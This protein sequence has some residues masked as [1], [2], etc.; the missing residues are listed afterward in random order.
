MVLAAAA[1]LGAYAAALAET[2]P[3]DSVTRIL[4]APEAP[5]G[6]AVLGFRGAVLDCLGDSP[7]VENRTAR[8][9]LRLESVSVRGRETS[10][11]G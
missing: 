10:V 7:Y 2:V 11:S 5:R 3:P 6:G 4:A 8:Y 9:L 1:A